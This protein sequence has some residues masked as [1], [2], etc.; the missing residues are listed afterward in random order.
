MSYCPRIGKKNYTR[1]FVGRIQLKDKRNGKINLK[2]HIK[3]ARQTEP[4]KSPK[5]YTT[6]G[7]PVGRILIFHTT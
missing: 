5:T 2:S 4:Q 3:P 6:K 7:Q 1:Y